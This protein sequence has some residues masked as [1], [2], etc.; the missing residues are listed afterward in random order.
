MAFMSV[1]ILLIVKDIPSTMT[2]IDNKGISLFNN[3]EKKARSGVTFK[4][5]DTDTNPV[6]PIMYTMGIIIKEENNKL[7][8][9]ISLFF[10]A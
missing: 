4:F 3:K 9:K 8:F 10:A 7:F 1:S 5:L 6:K 2:I